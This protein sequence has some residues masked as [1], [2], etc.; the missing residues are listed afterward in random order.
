MKDYNKELPNVEQLRNFDTEWTDECIAQYNAFIRLAERN[1]D[2]QFEL[3]EYDLEDCLATDKYFVAFDEDDFVYSIN[4][5]TNRIKK[6]KL[7]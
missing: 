5:K 6:S 2:T 7:F 3:L 4:P 1:S